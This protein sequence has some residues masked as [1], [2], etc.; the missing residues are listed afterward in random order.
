MSGKFAGLKPSEMEI[1]PDLLQVVEGFGGGGRTRTYDLRIMSRQ[2]ADDS[3]GFQQ[4]SSADSGKVPQNPQPP[5]NRKEATGP[6]ISIKPNDQS[7][8][9]HRESY[10]DND[11][12]ED[13][14][15]CRL[16]AHN[17]INKEE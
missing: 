7:G 4:D 8:K 3:K 2:P 9:P 5:R 12:R 11:T 6:A 10:P 17:G 1:P 16:A 15:P 13:T 14:V